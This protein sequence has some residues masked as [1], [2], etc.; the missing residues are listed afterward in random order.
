VR[1]GVHIVPRELFGIPIQTVAITATKLLPPAA[2]ETL[3][4]RILDR[5]LGDLSRYGINR[6]TE[7]ILQRVASS[8]RIP[9]I[10]VGTVQKISE[11]AIKVA[12]ALSAITSAGASFSGGNSHRF[13]AVILATGYRP[14]YQFFLTDRDVSNPDDHSCAERSSNSTIYFVGFYNSVAGLLRQISREAVEVAGD[15]ARR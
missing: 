15:I 6:P 13:D 5:A 9:V 3:F 10:D 14:N 4:P 7:G 2:S 12:P 1:N 8:G 11:G